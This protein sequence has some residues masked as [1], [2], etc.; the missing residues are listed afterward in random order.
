MDPQT[1]RRRT[2][3]TARRLGT[4]AA[5]AAAVPLG[6][7]LG[8]TGITADAVGQGNTI[9]YALGWSPAPAWAGGLARCWWGWHPPRR[10]RRALQRRAAGR[11]RVDLLRRDRRPRD[12]LRHQ[13]RHAAL[14]DRLDDGG[15]ARRAGRRP[16][17]LGQRTRRSLRGP[18]A[19]APSTACSRPRGCSCCGSTGSISAGPACWD[20]CCS[21]W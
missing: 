14:P 3:A 11:R 17:Q 20:G 7:A 9:G 13:H 8:V 10:R 16:R 19:G 18:C 12:P 4:P 6:A 21:R 15:G 2:A 5:L 1:E